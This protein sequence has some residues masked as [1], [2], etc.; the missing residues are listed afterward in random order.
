MEPEKFADAVLDEKWVS[1]MEEELRMIEKNDT[2]ELVDRPTHK[3]AIGVKWV[4]RTKLN[5]DG[6]INKHKARLVVKGYAQ[7]C[8]VDFSKTFA[9]VARLDTIRMLLAIVAQKGWKVARPVNL[10]YLKL[11]RLEKSFYLKSVP[12]LTRL[13][14]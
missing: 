13:Y 14:V 8:G 3:K 5:S 2:W 1:T 9:P 6:S 7:M 12:K 10:I 4:Y 11:G